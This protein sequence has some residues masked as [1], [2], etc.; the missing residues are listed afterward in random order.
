[1]RF[2]SQNVRSFYGAGSLETVASELGKHDLDLAAIQEFR[3]VK[4]GS[5]TAD[6]FLS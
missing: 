6:I 4:G 3:S 1:M 2:G 5:Q